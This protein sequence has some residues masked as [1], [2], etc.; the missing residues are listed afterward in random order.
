MQFSSLFRLP[1]GSKSFTVVS[2]VSVMACVYFSSRTALQELPL[3]H[4][5]F[6]DKDVRIE[7]I[8]EQKQADAMNIS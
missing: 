8:A 4:N 2:A 7:Y 3:Y 5:A 6:F 1:F